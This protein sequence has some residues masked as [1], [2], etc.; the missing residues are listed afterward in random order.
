[1][2]NKYIACFGFYDGLHAGHRVVLNKLKQIAKSQK[3]KTLVFSFDKKPDSVLRNIKID[4]ILTV[5]EKIK[6]LKQ[7]GIDEVKIIPFTKELSQLSYKEFLNI[8]LLDHYNIS[9][10]I[11]GY[12]TKIGKN[13]EGD[14]NKLSNYV[15]QF[16]IECIK[17][18]E[19]KDGQSL[20]SSS[21]IRNL[22]QT[23]EIEKANELLG[24]PYFIQ[25]QVVKGKQIGRKLGFPTANLAVEAKVLPNSGVFGVRVQHSSSTY[26]G[27]MNIGTNPSVGENNRKTLEVNIFEFEKEIYDESIKLEFLFKIREEQK[28]DSLDELK[29]QLQKDKEFCLAKSQ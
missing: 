27:M 11:L 20:I 15:A 25:A 19:L 7:Y 6:K 29:E 2:S 24:Y 16:D 3:A 4:Y 22:I 28:F 5:E 10:L 13:R 1:M 26:L 14:Y 8:H 18:E 12:D 23:S 17:L 21:V 9:H